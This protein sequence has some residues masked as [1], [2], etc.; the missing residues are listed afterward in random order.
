MK[1]FLL[2][3]FVVVFITGCIPLNSQK[4]ADLKEEVS[5][6]QI[7]YTEL[8]QN[9]A[10]LYTKLETI[11]TLNALIQ[12][13]DNKVSLLNQS[14]R[15][16]EIKLNNTKNE[17]SAILPVFVYQ[18]AYGDY[19]VGKYELSYSEFKSFVEKYPNDKQAYQAQFYMG[20]CFYSLGLWEKAIAEYA[21]VEEYY[22]KSNLI[23][24]SRLK[25]ALCYE[26]LGNKNEAI[27]IFKSIV[28]DF[29]QSSESLIAKEKI[30][31][32]NN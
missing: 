8:Q 32:Y 26:M 28:Q 12:D 14:M 21:K 29:S 5:K 9:N 4:I 16:F 15:D 7:Q 6:L 18:N 11:N 19:L 3:C 27:K 2:L 24:A 1:Q 31:I 23:S 20:E 22:K 13:L 10:D 17:S 30:K 25:I